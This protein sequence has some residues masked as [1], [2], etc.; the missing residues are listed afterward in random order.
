MTADVSIVDQRRSN[1][2]YLPSAAITT[3]GTRSTVELLRTG[4]RP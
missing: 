1:V 3:T 2:L 4:R